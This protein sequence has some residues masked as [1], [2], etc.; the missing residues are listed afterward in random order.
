MDYK[1]K[2]MMELWHI[3]LTGAIALVIWFLR[4]KHEM[5]TMGRKRYDY[6]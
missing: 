6:K 3:L 5:A 1:E 4:F 2:K